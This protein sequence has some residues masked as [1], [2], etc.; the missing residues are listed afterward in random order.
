MKKFFRKMCKQAEAQ[1]AIAIDSARCARERNWIISDLD[2]C[3]Y[4]DS[5]SPCKIP[6][7]DPW[8][9][10]Q[11]M[12]RA[13]TGSDYCTPPSWYMILIT[14]GWTLGLRRPRP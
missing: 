13:L 6:H 11:W 8:I 2:A 14:G 7:G 9:A 3:D 10:W 12:E 1:Y 4:C 5:H